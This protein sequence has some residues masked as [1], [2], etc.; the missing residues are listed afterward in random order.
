MI[1]NQES[2]CFMCFEDYQLSDISY[3]CEKECFINI[4]DKHLICENCISKWCEVNKRLNINRIE[5][6]CPG[7]KNWSFKLIDIEGDSVYFDTDEYTSSDSDEEI[8][9][10][11]NLNNNNLNNQNKCHFNLFRITFKKIKMILTRCFSKCFE[12]YSFCYFLIIYLVTVILIGFIVS[13][14]WLFII[15]YDCDKDTFYNEIIVK[16]WTE[17]YYY[18][19]ICPVYACFFIILVLFCI[20]C[21]KE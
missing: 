17:S 14:L 13:S 5:Y 7:C 20:K 15:V 21:F 19:G 3:L 12:K 16:K 18:L 1:D 10:Y 9:D 11:N 4:K 6:K 2:I 8:I